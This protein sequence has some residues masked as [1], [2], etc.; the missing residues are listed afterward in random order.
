VYV[1]DILGWGF[2]EAGGAKTYS[3][4][5]KIDHLKAFIRQ[6]V[7][8]NGG[9]CVLC[10][11]S[12]GGA[13]AMILAVEG[14]TSLVSDVV[15][16]DAQGFIDGKGPSDI[17]D[18]FAEFG[19]SILQSRPLRMLANLM[20]YNDIKTF[21]T[22]DAMLCGRIHTLLPWWK[23][24]SVD[25]LKSGGFI[26]SDKVPAMTQRTLVMWGSQDNILPPSDAQRFRDILPNCQKM[27]YVDQCGHV[28]HLEQ[29]EL[30]AAE[31]LKLLGDDR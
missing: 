1:P 30:A 21:A 13:V 26:I 12:L 31:I 4:Q 3:P 11:A 22:W 17:A 29:K 23:R 25:F 5:A 10:G 14:G 8:P 19:V 16:I 20:S 27:I 28:P 15:L 9:P 7:T 6:I 24:A 18:P 2:S